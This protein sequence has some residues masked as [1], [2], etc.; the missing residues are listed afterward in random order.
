MLCQFLL[1]SRVKQLYIY[2]H[3]PFFWISF[4]FRS[5][6]STEQSRFSLVSYFLCIS[7]VYMSVPISQCT[8]S[9]FPPWHPHICSLCLSL[10]FCFVDK[11][12]YTNFFFR[13]YMYVLMYNICFSFSD[14]LQLCMTVSRSIHVLTNDPILFLFITNIL[15]TMYT[16]SSLFIPL[17]D[18]Q[19]AS[20]S[21]LL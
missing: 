18:I 19:I 15:L 16:T 7:S 3:L 17:L 11:I 12:V 2:K 21:W 5:P 9:P 13:F 1:Y 8:P 10:Y 6:Q 4:P 14:L 20:R